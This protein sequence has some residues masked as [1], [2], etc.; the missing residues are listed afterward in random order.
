[1][2]AS[3][4]NTQSTQP[5][6][7]THT[8]HHTH[9]HI[10]TRTYIHIHAHTHTFMHTHTHTHTHTFTWHYFSQFIYL[11]YH[12]SLFLF[13]YLMIFLCT[14]ILHFDSLVTCQSMFGY[15]MLAF[16]T[17]T[18]MKIRVQISI[19]TCFLLFCIYF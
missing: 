9:I 17:G 3:G 18:A 7:L 12:I 6:E 8:L 2:L 1:M 14:N 11:V 4:L 10:H 15:F 5:C 19:L 16:V 13:Y